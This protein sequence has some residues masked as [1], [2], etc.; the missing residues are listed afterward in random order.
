M[1]GAD[2]Y[3]FV[4]YGDDSSLDRF[5]LVVWPLSSG[6]YPTTTLVYDNRAGADYDLDIAD[7]QPI[8]AGSV[9]VHH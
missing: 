1:N 7:R 9:Q 4:V 8:G 3:G 2:G 5:R 6:P